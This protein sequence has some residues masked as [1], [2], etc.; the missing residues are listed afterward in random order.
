[1][2]LVLNV[3]PSTCFEFQNGLEFVI[4]LYLLL[5]LFHLGK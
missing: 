5:F 2:T 1:L 4:L 3:N